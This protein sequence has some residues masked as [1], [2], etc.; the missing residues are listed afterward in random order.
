MAADG[1]EVKRLMNELRNSP[2]FKV[3][4]EINNNKRSLRILSRDK[5]ELVEAIAVL[6]KQMLSGPQG[7]TNESPSLAL[8]LEEL[9]RRLESFLCS[10]ADLI[11]YTRRYCRKLYENTEHAREIQS[12]IDRRFIFEADYKLAQ[13][14]RYMPAHIESLQASLPPIQTNEEREASYKLQVK[15]LLAW[16]EWNDNQRRMLEAMKD[17]IDV[18]DFAERYFRKTEAFY[19]WLWKLQGEIHADDLRQAE[20]MRLK[21]KEAYD[22]LFPPAST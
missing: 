13:G 3:H 4:S 18:Q 1:S 12:E 6:K 7:S 16:D 14:L 11:E 8:A 20:E 9:A 17:D 19:S 10:S 5:D 22:R 2:G 21:A 15:Q